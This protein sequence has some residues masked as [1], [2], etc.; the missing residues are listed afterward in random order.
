MHVYLW[1]FLLS[2]PLFTR[3][4]AAM[5]GSS[6]HVLPNRMRVIV[7][8]RSHNK[9]LALNLF[10]NGGSG[11]DPE[12]KQGL[13]NLTQRLLIKGAAGKNAEQIAETIESVGGRIGVSTSEDYCELFTV[14]TADELDVALGLLADVALHP[15]FPP[16]EIDRERQLVLSGI[17]R[18]A[19]SQFA[20]TYAEFLRQ[21]YGN[22]PYGHPPDGEELPVRS[23]SRQDI[24]EYQAYRC[25]P[26]KLVLSV[27]GDVNADELVKKVQGLFQQFPAVPSEPRFIVAHALQPHFAKITLRKDCRQAFVIAGFPAL[28]ISDPAYPALRVANAMLGEGMSARLFRRL[29]DNQSLA[30]TVGSSVDARKLG[31]HMALWIGTNPVNAETARLALLDEAQHLVADATEDELQRAKQYI[32]GKHLIARQSNHAKAHSAGVY[33]VLGM[34]Y[35]FDDSFVGRI[36]AVTRPQA[37]SALA[38]IIKVPVSVT[39][40]PEG[41]EPI[42]PEQVLDLSGPQP[43]IHMP[44]ETE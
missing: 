19:D 4:V 29:R 10:F 35:Q 3:G 6:M 41:Q 8:S 14:T 40:L 36:E 42:P 16:A 33:E 7:T 31:G 38:N 25:Q 24:L 21:M 9:V 39:L 15:T 28:P 1:I 22:H 17:A 18:R 13:A 23:I 44:T 43:T 5:T 30:Y 32:T 11:E 34:G 12:G 2:G 37:I 26:E 20:Y 27:C